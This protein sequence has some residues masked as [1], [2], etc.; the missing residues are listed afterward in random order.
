MVRVLKYLL[1]TGVIAL[2][3]FPLAQNLWNVL[4]PW[5]LNGSYEPAPQ[6]E[7]S[8][9]DW[10]DGNYQPGKEKWL[11][12]NIGAREYL[13]RLRN[14]YYFSVFHVAKA[15]GVIPCKNG[16][17]V[18]QGY[19]DAF[20]GNDFAGEEFLNAQ[21]SSWKRVQEGL[22]SLGIRSFVALAPGKASFF[23]EDFPEFLRQEPKPITNYEYIRTWSED[24]GVN[25]LDLKHLF[26]LWNDTSSYPLFPKGGI[27]WSEYAAAIVCDTLRG[28]IQNLTGRPL[29]K[30][31]Y[32]ISIS[33]TARGGD[34]DIADGMNLLFTPKKERLAYPIRYFG[35]D[36]TIAPTRLL[37]IADSYYYALIYSGFADRVVSYGGFWYYFRQ[38]EPGHLFGN[39]MVEELDLVE[40]LK[41]QD[42]LMLLMTEPQMQRFSWGAAETL[43]QAL[44]PTSETAR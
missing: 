22:D 19:A 16:V 21:L 42:V 39:K 24:N 44:Y 43:E 9:N 32:D 34:N 14:Q 3:F 36:S 8:W 29:Q 12:E 15:N 25:V 27:H 7:F 23:E 26:H 10:F 6:V 18:D 37:V 33:D 20:Y 30:F 5:K 35:E 2:L 13:I 4:P 31:W 1:M 40:E 41:K 17:L 11:N 28:Y 38:A